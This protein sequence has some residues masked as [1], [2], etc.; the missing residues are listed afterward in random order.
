LFDTIRIIAAEIA[1]DL[2]AEL[3]VARR[4]RPGSGRRQAWADYQPMKCDGSLILFLVLVL[5]GGLAI[6]FLTAPGEWYAGLGKPGFNPPNWLFAPVWTVLYVLIAVAGWRV[7]RKDASGWPMW[8]WCAQLL[9]NLLWSPTFFAAHQIGV[10]FLV[11]LLLL[12]SIL[13]FIFTAWRQDRAAAW[14][15]IPYTAWVGF[16]SVLNGSILVMN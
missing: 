5:G 13:A 10:A 11:I 8:L 2:E 14:L 6:G 12:V 4:S 7:W 9:L 16:A 3:A 15:F 1:D